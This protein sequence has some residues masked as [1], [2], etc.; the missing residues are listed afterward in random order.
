MQIDELW[1]GG[2]RFLQRPPV[3]KL[4]T[5]SVLLAYFANT[6]RKKRAVDLGSGTGVLAVLLAIQAPALT[7]DCVDILPEAV[8]LT[9]ENIRLNGLD[10]RIRAHL[11]DIRSIPGTLAAGA[12][13]L[14]VANPPYFPAG[15]GKRALGGALADARDESLC[16]L[17]DLCGAAAYLLTWGGR[18]AVVHRPERL[19]ELFV[20]MHCAGIEPKRLRTVALSAARA[21]NL[22]LVEGH[23]GGN[24]GLLI[25]PPLILQEQDGGE[26]AEVRAIYHRPEM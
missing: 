19:S 12:Y 16:T 1:P 4:G 6:T 9:I 26:S 23:R 13:D 18:F 2:P 25:E 5:D 7:V 10:S 8:D 17:E 14:A 20:A 22:I 15:G 3:F 21:P 24:P 11:G